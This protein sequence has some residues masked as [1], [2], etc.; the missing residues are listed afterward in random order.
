MK[1]KSSIII[2]LSLICSY[3]FASTVLWDHMTIIDHHYLIGN[4]KILPKTEYDNLYNYAGYYSICVAPAADIEVE[5]PKYGNKRTI[6]A[7]SEQLLAHACNF[8]QLN[9]GDIVSAATTKN[10][11]EYF[12]E[13]LTTAD[14]SA[15]PGYSITGNVGDDFYLGFVY[16]AG[17]SNSVDEPFWYRDVYGWLHMQFT[18]DGVEML[19]SAINLD[20]DPITVG[21]VPEPSSALLALAGAALLIKRRK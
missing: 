12:L 2:L 15:Y 17:F 1:I 13:Y 4:Y 16:E 6:S 9:E 11:D 8:V 10:Q 14:G 21:V 7:S 5:I 18:T 3:T 20:G 19:Y